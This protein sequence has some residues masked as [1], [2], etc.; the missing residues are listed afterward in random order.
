LSLLLKPAFIIR[1][2][3]SELTPE[4]FSQHHWDPRTRAARDAAEGVV[5]FADAVRAH[6]RSTVPTRE[7]PLELAYDG[8]G[9]PLQSGVRAAPIMRARPARC[10]DK[11]PVAALLYRPAP[12]G[13]DVSVRLCPLR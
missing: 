2:R 9:S 4:P 10:C 12:K 13:I 8:S 7:L 1:S 11:K 3:A 5:E 6:G